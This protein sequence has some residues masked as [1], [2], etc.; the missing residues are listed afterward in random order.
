[1]RYLWP[2]NING[3]SNLAIVVEACTNLANPIWLPVGTNTLSGGSSYFRDAQWMNYPA[4]FYRLRS[5]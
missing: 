5:P 2:V 1:V 3:S 4:R